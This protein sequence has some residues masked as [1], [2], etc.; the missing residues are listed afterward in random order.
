[1]EYR[2]TFELTE[3]A[4]SQELVVWVRYAR[5]ESHAAYL[6]HKAA[7]DH[8]FYTYGDGAEAPS[9]SLE[10]AWTWALADQVKNVRAVIETN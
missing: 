5:S 10:S 9:D 8:V 1:M 4:P 6:A 2:V 3:D 7:V